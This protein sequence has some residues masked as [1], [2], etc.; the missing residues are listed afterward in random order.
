MKRFTLRRVLRVMLAFELAA[1]VGCAPAQRI[2][3]TDPVDRSGHPVPWDEVR[4]L[5][6]EQGRIVRLS[7]GETVRLRDGVVQIVPA[8][9]TA[10]RS[11]APGPS[12][13]GAS[14]TSWEL[15]D[16]AAVDVAESAS[17]T[18]RIEVL[19]PDDLFAKEH[20]PRVE[21]ITLRDGT[22]IALDANA[23][24]PHLDMGGAELVL[25]RPGAES[26]TIP[27]AEIATLQVARPG[28]VGST[29]RSPGAWLVTAAAAGVL[30]LVISTRDTKNTAVK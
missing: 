18:R 21:Q 22:H 19:T 23:R 4:V 28:F 12:S 7:T 14:S 30:V 3:S 26:L 16:L 11:D 8:S 10:A 5:E 24:G 13:G 6:S 1:G 25:P 29:L 20:E 27:V 9:T 17:K 15:A 2:Y